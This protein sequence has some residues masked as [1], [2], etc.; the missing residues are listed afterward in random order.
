[1]GAS[2]RWFLCDFESDCSK[3]VLAGTGGEDVRK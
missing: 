1:L 2:A 3:H